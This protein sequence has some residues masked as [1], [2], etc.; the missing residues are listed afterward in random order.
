MSRLLDRFSARDNAADRPKIGLRGFAPLLAHDGP[1][2][3]TFERTITELKPRKLA[4]KLAFMFEARLVI[5]P[6]RF[7]LETPTLQRDY[8]ACWAGFEKLFDIEG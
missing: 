8:D 2:R 6:T 5:W 3:A 4:D 1:P 7:A